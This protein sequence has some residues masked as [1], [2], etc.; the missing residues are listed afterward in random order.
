[1]F[2]FIFKISKC[3]VVRRLSQV[4]FDAHSGV[5]AQKLRKTGCFILYLQRIFNVTNQNDCTKRKKGE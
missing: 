1:M 5:N 3:H 2:F 4:C